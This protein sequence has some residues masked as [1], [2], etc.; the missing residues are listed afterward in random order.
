[1]NNFTAIDVPLNKI[2]SNATAIDVIC[3]IWESLTD[4]AH[5]HSIPDT[6]KLLPEVYNWIHRRLDSFFPV[7]IC[8]PF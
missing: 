1:V 4:V 7:T 6:P 3:N 8:K 2:R 5:A